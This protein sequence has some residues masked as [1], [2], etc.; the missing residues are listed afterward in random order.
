MLYLISDTHFGHENVLKYESI[1]LNLLS[2]EDKNKPIEEQILL[3]NEALIKNWN[4]IVKDTDT[5]FC[6]GDFALGGLEKNNNIRN[7]SK[8]L[9]GE[10]ILIRGNHDVK[11]PSIYLESGWKEVKDYVLINDILFCHY[12]I[13]SEETTSTWGVEKEFREMYRNSLEYKFVIHGHSHSYNYDLKNHFNVSVENIEF[14]PIS[15]NQ[16]L[17]YFNK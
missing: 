15:I 14:K 7:I 13:G 16:V 11:D 6:M 1:R 9:N 5:I 12:P 4:D 3:M 17:K 2:P 10:K 8:R